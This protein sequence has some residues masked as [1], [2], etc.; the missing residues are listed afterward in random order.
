MQSSSLHT[1]F[2]VELTIKS[3]IRTDSSEPVTNI[4]SLESSVS[5]IFESEY[6]LKKVEMLKIKSEFC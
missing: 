4:N 2:S 6:V 1:F 5:T 3:Q